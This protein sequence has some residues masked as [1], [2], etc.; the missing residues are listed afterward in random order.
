MSAYPVTYDEVNDAVLVINSLA[1]ACNNPGTN[2]FAQCECKHQLYL[3]KCLLED[4]YKDLPTF[5]AQEKDW[6][7]ERLIQ[8]LKRE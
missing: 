1:Q 3:L 8:L 7:Q 2:I 6:E 5:P 4:V